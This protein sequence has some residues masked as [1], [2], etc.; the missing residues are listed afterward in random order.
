MQE[1]FDAGFE[2]RLPDF[3]D[4]CLKEYSNAGKARQNLLYHY[5]YSHL[6]LIGTSLTRAVETAGYTSFSCKKIHYLKV[7]VNLVRET[8]GKGTG[9]KVGYFFDSLASFRKLEI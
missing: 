5:A 9:S 1:Y 4:D 3:F 6:A 7:C 2:N 8:D